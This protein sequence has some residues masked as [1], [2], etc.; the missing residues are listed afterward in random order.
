MD[1]EILKA[2]E[3]IESKLKNMPSQTDVAILADRL[4]QVE[5]KSSAQKDVFIGGSGMSLGQQVQKQFAAQ[6]D[7]FRKHKVLA[8]DIETKAIGSLA[9]GARSSLEPVTAAEAQTVVQLLPKLRM[10]PAGGVAGITYGRRSVGIV[11]PGASV[12]S[13]NGVRPKSEPVYSSIVQ[14]LVTVAAFAELS[15]TSLRTSGELQNV[16]D[17]HL[18][19]DIFK[20]ADLLMLAGGTNFAPGLLGL[21]TVSVLPNTIG[22]LLEEIVAVGAMNLRVDGFSPDVVCVNP[23]DWRA[24]YL[25]KETSGAY[26][27]ASP[28]G[29]PP[30]EISG[31][32]VVFSTAVATNTALLLDSRYCDFMPSENI[33][34][35]LAYTNTQFL[36]G[37]LTV[38]AELQGLP[39][40]RDLGA[41]VLVS[42]AP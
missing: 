30:L 12:V 29:L 23:L 17:L 36:S 8:L 37:E 6:A 38:R 26:I 41:A 25:R 14:N 31:L 10:Q 22:N 34:I 20:A 9:A 39:V 21:A 32:E 35:E 24:V 18:Q 11:G 40:L 1:H 16:V 13:E 28:L 42:R 15:E 2:C 33:R 7:S 5:Q 19:R 4:L 3:A 27:H